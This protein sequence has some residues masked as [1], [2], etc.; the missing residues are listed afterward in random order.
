MLDELLANP[1][2]IIT[3]II[4]G[5]F[6]IGLII[7]GTAHK[8]YYNL[9]AKYDQIENTTGMPTFKVLEYGIRENKQKTKLYIAGDKV[10]DCYDYVNDNIILKEDIFYGTSV[11]SLAV[12]SHEFG[13]SM[14]RYNNS[15]WFAMCYFFNK[16][17]SF[18]SGLFF[19]LVLIGLIIWL[20]PFELNIIGE[21]MIYAGLFSFAVTLLTKIFLIPLE[22]GA[23]K[24]ARKFLKKQIGI[25]GRELNQVRKLLNAAGMTYVASLFAT[26][27]KVIRY[28]VKGYWFQYIKVS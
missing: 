24:N 6:L 15:F 27:Y 28:I 20:I 9:K 14:Q 11:A 13:H 1:L 3:V 22:F 26:P 18:F 2:F 17:N 8:H 25:K 12:A 16:L 4:I 5:L 7:A 21:V 10:E 23:S 19:P